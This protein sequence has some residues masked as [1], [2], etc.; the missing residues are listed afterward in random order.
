M[1]RYEGGYAH[2]ACIEGR[3]FEDA[4]SEGHAP[5]HGEAPDEP[6]PPR[7]PRVA[8]ARP[9]EPFNSDGSLNL[10]SYAMLA[11][12]GMVELAHRL[13]AE[14]TAKV[15][16]ETG[17][18]GSVSM[19]QVKSLARTLL[20]AADQVQAA[21]REDGHVDRM[22]SSHTRSRGAVRESLWVFPVPWGASP[23]DQAAWL[24]K[25]TAH[26]TGLVRIAVELHT[27]RS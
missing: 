11:T 15:L 1:R 13:A 5:P 9:W 3:P 12:V 2:V 23:E 24:G 19:A 8:E 16:A 14:R 21:N 17:V 22:D 20:E 27:G 18:S 10:G 26:A 7:R 6:V 4:P 25:L